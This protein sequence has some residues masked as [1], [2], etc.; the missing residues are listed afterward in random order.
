MKSEDVTIEQTGNDIQAI[1]VTG[2]QYVPA[3]TMNLTTARHSEPPRCG[4]LIMTVYRLDIPEP[5]QFQQMVGW[6]CHA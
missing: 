4:R 5:N 1:K 2:D 3:G 6:N